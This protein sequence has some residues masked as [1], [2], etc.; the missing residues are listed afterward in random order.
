MDGKTILYR[1]PSGLVA[2][3]LLR[4][5][6]REDAKVKIEISDEIKSLFPPGSNMVLTG[7]IENGV[8]KVTLELERNEAV[9]Y[10]SRP[11]TIGVD[12]EQR[13]A[14]KAEV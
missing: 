2:H 7:V 12:L 9:E 10:L 8:S 13:F 4:Y 3:E 6:T 5:I 11:M 14:D 1:G